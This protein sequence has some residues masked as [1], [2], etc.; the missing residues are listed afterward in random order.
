MDSDKYSIQLIKKDIILP[1][2]EE[3][4]ISQYELAMRT[5]LA[6][7]TITRWFHGEMVISSENLI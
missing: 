2:M 6:F 3:K 7:S 1:R 5:G 4:R